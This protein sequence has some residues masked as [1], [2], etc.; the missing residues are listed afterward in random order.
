LQAFAVLRQ[1]GI[2]P[3]ELRRQVLP[4]LLQRDHLAPQV[5]DEDGAL[6]GKVTQERLV[7][8]LGDDQRVIP[9]NGDTPRGKDGEKA[10]ARA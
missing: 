2:L 8:F 6:V 4:D 9:G 3:V 1:D 7:R 10:V 5:L